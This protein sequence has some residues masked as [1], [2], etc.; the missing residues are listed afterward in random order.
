MDADAAPTRTAGT[1]HPQGASST[2]LRRELHGPAW[3]KW[4]HLLVGAADGLLLPIEFEGRL[5]KTGA[6][7]HRPGFAVDHQ[8]CGPF[9]HQWTAEVS[10]INV[11][12]RQVGLLR[13]EIC[14]D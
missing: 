1:A 10:P 9:A 4:H 13:A 6:V 2:D 12:F 3:L 5:G 8:V 7:A 11:Q 14:L